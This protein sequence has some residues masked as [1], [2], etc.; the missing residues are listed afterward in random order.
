[1]LPEIPP[2]NSNRIPDGTGVFE[3]VASLGCDIVTPIR[4]TSPYFASIW[5]RRFF[6]PLGLQ[7]TGNFVQRRGSA[8]VQFFYHAVPTIEIA[9]QDTVEGCPI[10]KIQ[11]WPGAPQ[12][13]ILKCFI[14]KPSPV[15]GADK[16][17][18]S[19]TLQHI[20]H[21]RRHALDSSNGILRLAQHGVVDVTR[22][23]R[24]WGVFHFHYLSWAI[25][26]LSFN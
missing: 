11:P 12:Y 17:P 8:L 10:R 20:Q 24:D 4:S 3:R 2:P 1:M 7:L 18:P 16:N 26:R 25:A 14:L 23:K 13:P 6:G 9:P 22:V 5:Q 19:L 15:G 21:E